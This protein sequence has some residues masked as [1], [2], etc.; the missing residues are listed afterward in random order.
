MQRRLPVKR[1]KKFRHA[2]KRAKNLMR[3]AETLDEMFKWY[4]GWHAHLYRHWKKTCPIY[5]SLQEDTSWLYAF[6]PNGKV[7]GE[8]ITLGDI[9]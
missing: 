4:F 3:T 1:F 6:T 7:Y 2:K 5:R 8:S 9:K